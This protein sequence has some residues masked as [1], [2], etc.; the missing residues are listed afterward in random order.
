MLERFKKEPD[1]AQTLK[2]GVRVVG[3]VFSKEYVGDP[4]RTGSGMVMREV[5]VIVEDP[6]GVLRDV[7]TGRPAHT[8]ETTAVEARFLEAGDNGQAS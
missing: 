8:I 7:A 3:R 5:E 4:V 6:H 2:V 1:D